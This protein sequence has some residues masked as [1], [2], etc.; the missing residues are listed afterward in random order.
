MPRP[1]PARSARTPKFLAGALCLDFANTLSGRMDAEPVERIRDYT[2]LA[3]WGVQAGVLADSAAKGL[4]RT[5]RR[6]PKEAD[7]VVARAADLR[8]A[9]H[10]AFV[11]RAAGRG[12]DAQAI[13]RIDAEWADA[14]RHRR[15]GL[16]DGR[17]TWQWE[18][19]SDAL[20][21][22]LWPVAQSAAE[23][24]TAADP[25]RVKECPGTGCGWLFLDRSK[26][27][28]RR[29]CEMEVCGNRAKARRFNKR[30]NAAHPG[31]Q[32]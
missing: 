17:V 14:G 29:W 31:G 27:S 30:R 19:V 18:E 24:L 3:N 26:N 32:G 6:R 23:M 16:L 11:A 21:R 8:G 7:A 9:I 13:A 1:D 28:S 4:L 20:D 10:K 5:A 12:P 22:V 25:A 15:L 2:D